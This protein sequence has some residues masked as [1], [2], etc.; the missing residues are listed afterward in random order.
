MSLNSQL[1]H[2]HIFFFGFTLLT[3]ITNV[4]GSSGLEEEEIG[5]DDS[6]L[7]RQSAL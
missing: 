5:L 2:L 4:H 1:Y 3:Q 6:M 7:N